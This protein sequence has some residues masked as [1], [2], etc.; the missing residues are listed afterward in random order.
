[1]TLSFYQSLVRCCI[2][3]LY[4]PPPAPPLYLSNSLSIYC[5]MLYTSTCAYLL[6]LLSI[7]L[8]LY[9]VYISLSNYLF[10]FCYM[11]FTYLPVLPPP[12]PPHYLSISL[13]L[14]CRMLFT[15][16]YLT[17]SLSIHCYML[18]TSSC[19]YLLL[20]LPSI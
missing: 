2:H 18:Y 16:L 19:T 3:L 12:A 9:V 6:L 13:S 5:C 4:L 7:Y 8:L 14:Y 20:L 11:L 17:I 15:S 1:M 10:I